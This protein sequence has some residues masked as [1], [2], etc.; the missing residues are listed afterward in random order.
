ML[1][2]AVC[3]QHNM[4]STLFGDW[5][6]GSLKVVVVVPILVFVVVIVVR[7]VTFSKH[8]KYR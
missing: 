6:S 4:H 7:L 8:C 1:E 5:W 2:S 3:G